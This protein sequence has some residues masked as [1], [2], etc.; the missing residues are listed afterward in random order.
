M[1]KT[2]DGDTLE[3]APWRM[4]RLMR[5]VAEMRRYPPG[6]PP[7][8]LVNDLRLIIARARRVSTQPRL[9]TARFESANACCRACLLARQQRGGME[10]VG[11]RLAAPMPGGHLYEGFA[12]ELEEEIRREVVGEKLDWKKLP[13][14]DAAVADPTVTGPGVY[15]FVSG[16][17]PRY[18]G[19][20]T[21]LQTRMKAHRW[22]AGVHG[23]RHRLSVWVTRVSQAENLRAVEHAIIRALRDSL[24][25]SA[26][27]NEV[28]RAGPRGI[29]IRNVLPAELL[30]RA[31]YIKDYLA[32]SAQRDLA[33]PAGKTLE[34]EWRLP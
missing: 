18:V 16:L 23:R 15:I 7:Q 34:L 6:T 33:M 4:R 8:A 10:L 1:F 13:S 14:L 19:M 28:L 32:G 27:V 29:T 12:P 31:R 24:H 26:L 2:A 22:C 30:S 3:L 9:G 25:N 17:V 5:L 20:S 11:L 21:T